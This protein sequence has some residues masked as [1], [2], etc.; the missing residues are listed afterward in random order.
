MAEVFAEYEIA[1]S[2]DGWSFANLAKNGS[3]EGGSRLVSVDVE[4]GKETVLSQKEWAGG[5]GI[6]WLADGS[7]IV[8]GFFESGNSPTQVWLIP[9]G[10]GEPRKITSDL[11]N[12][13]SIDISADGQTII[14]GQ[15]KDESSLWVQP[16]GKPDEARPVT[17]EKHHLFRWVRW[18]GEGD[19]VFGSSIGP[20]RDVW[21]MDTQGA[22]Q[23]QI[24]SGAKNNIMPA[25][26]RDGKTIYFCS[27]RAGKGVFNIYRT[28]ADGQTVDQLTSGDGEFQPAVSPDGKW[29][30]Y[31]AGNPGGDELKWT[32][33]KLP[34]SGGDPVQLTRQP[35]FYPVVSPDSRFLA[36]WI[37]PTDGQKW[38]VAIMSVDSGRV[39]KTLDIPRSN[40]LGWNAAGT[41]ISFIKTVD[42]VGNIWTQP[43]GGG[44]PAQETKF[45][46]DQTSNFDWSAKGDL[47]CTRNG[48]RRDVFL[49]RNFR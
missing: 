10:N 48:R 12:Y 19:L 7:G 13:G 29:I 9:I 21:A 20:D 33:W 39:E 15:F 42:D 3:A 14:A 4:T 28:T 16:P 6:A 41:G 1:W 8:G 37:M 24:T 43:I 38:Q 47:V 26:S 5:D 36:F 31:T 49:I 44:P 46:S 30:Y 35:S 18:L 32:V 2:P 23:R 25:A 45:T 17:N 40:P 11:E 34:A 27:N 22:N